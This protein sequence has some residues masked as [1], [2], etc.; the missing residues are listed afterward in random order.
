MAWCLY[1]LLAGGNIY[2]VGCKNSGLIDALQPL[3]LVSDWIVLIGYMVSES[4]DFGE[5]SP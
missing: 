4:E 3:E 5:Y 2:Y 1:G